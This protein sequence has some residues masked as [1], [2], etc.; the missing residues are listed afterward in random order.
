MSG[1]ST[2]KTNML[3]KVFVLLILAVVTN[4]S[5]ALAQRGRNACLADAQRL[6]ASVQPGG[7]RI[8]A[9]LEQNEAKL[10]S[11]CK[12]LVARFGDSGATR[13]DASRNGQSG[14]TGRQN[15]NANPDGK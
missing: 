13:G 7:G 9:C 5:P 15:A 2:E 8:L 4:V 6:C 10:T 14:S 11:Q 1:N 12:K 3:R